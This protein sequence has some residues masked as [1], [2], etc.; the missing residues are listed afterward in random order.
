MDF[1]Y[2]FNVLLKTKLAYTCNN[3]IY[4][5]ITT[6]FPLWG[7]GYYDGMLSG[8]FSYQNKMYYGK[9]YQ[10]T[11]S[12]ARRWY[13]LYPLTQDEEIALRKNLYIR[14]TNNYGCLY[15]TDLGKFEPIYSQIFDSNIDYGNFQNA[16][17][18]ERKSIGYTN[19]DFK[20]F[21]RLSTLENYSILIKAS[22]YPIKLWYKFLSLIDR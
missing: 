7:L 2:H 17:R 6:A 8:I 13:W 1:S 14:L 21:K 22:P 5:R 20:K 19:V 11:D 3:K 12:K 15:V 16:R 18:D 10:S 4:I 9:C